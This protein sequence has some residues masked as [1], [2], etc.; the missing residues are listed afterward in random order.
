MAS[1]SNLNWIVFQLLKISENDEKYPNILIPDFQTEES[2]VCCTKVVYSYFSNTRPDI[3]QSD[4]SLAVKYYIATYLWVNGAIIK[5]PKPEPQT[6]MPVAKARF[7]S[8]YI[9]TH[10][11]AGKYMRPNP[12]PEKNIIC[13]CKKLISVVRNK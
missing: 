6:A 2:L 3:C 1:K 9:D 7:F 10:T 13:S 8:K 4:P 11:I 5:V 12:I